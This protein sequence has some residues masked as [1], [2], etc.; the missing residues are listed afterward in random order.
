M[1]SARP[2]YPPA[3]P[4]SANIPLHPQLGEV[5]EGSRISWLTPPCTPLHPQVRMI[6][7]GYRIGRLEG[8]AAA[9][10]GGPARSHRPVPEVDPGTYRL[11][12]EGEGLRAVRW[13]T[14]W[15]EVAGGRGRGGGGSSWVGWSRPLPRCVCPL[16]AHPVCM[17]DPND[18]DPMA[19]FKQHTSPLTH[20]PACPL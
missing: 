15:Q 13:H 20:P 1:G 7:D 18:P 17:R 6:L 11:R 9:G 14:G 8:G 5:L 19:L 2:T 10:V 12:L 3:H 16:K 4:P